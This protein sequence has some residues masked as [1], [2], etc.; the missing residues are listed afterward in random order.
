MSSDTSGAIATAYGNAFAG[1]GQFGAAGAQ[2]AAVGAGGDLGPEPIPFERFV[3][4][5][6]A[7]GI[8]AERGGDPNALL[9]QFG[10]NAPDWGNLGMYWNKRMAQEATKYHALFTEY[11]AKYRAKYGG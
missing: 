11:S 9:A 3:E 1:G 4:I 10:I 8:T 7:M 6:E 5:Q 2:A